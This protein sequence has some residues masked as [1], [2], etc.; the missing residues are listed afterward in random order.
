MAENGMTIE[1]SSL[2]EFLSVIYEKAAE[3]AG[4]KIG[5]DAVKDAV[6]TMIENAETSMKKVSEDD[7]Q[8]LKDAAINLLDT[9]SLWKE[10]LDSL[11]RSTIMEN[12]FIKSGTS[13][14]DIFK[15]IKTRIIT[16]QEELDKVQNKITFLLYVTEDGDLLL[17]D[18]LAILKEASKWKKAGGKSSVVDQSMAKIARL[19]QSRLTDWSNL[20][21]VR[22]YFL[23]DPKETRISLSESF[24]GMGEE[25][26]KKSLFYNNKRFWTSFWNEK[27]G[28]DKKWLI[29]GSLFPVCSYYDKKDLGKTVVAFWIKKAQNGAVEEA[30]SQI[31]LNAAFGIGDVSDNI[32]DQTK[33]GQIKFYEYMKNADNKPGLTSADLMYNLN[34]AKQALTDFQINFSIKSGSSASSQSWGFY[35][36]IAQAIKDSGD[37][38]TINEVEKIFKEKNAQYQTKLV[39]EVNKKIIKEMKKKAKKKGQI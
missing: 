13:V 11:S 31:L 35:Y 37:A 29:G 20:K 25:A 9:E 8:P 22:E 4:E 32:F 7:L 15:L 19:S 39:S 10:M 21:T 6:K 23:Q 33:E 34:N 18:E 14:S 28:K 26:Y 27:K 5:T 1:A 36:T 30:Y 12:K 3:Q 38:L 16:F 24:V 2:D 17:D